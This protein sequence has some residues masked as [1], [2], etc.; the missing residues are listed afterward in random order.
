MREDCKDKIRK[1]YHTPELTVYGDVRA[2]TET[3]KGNSGDNA[4]NDG[5]KSH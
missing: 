4:G 3:G 2:I 1:T 5:N